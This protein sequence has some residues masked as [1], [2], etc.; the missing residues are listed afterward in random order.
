MEFLFPKYKKIKALAF[1]PPCPMPMTSNNIEMEHGQFGK[2]T[3][4]EGGEEEEN[5]FGPRCST[6]RL[7]KIHSLQ[8]KQD[9]EC[10]EGFGYFLSP[11]PYSL[12]ALGQLRNC[13][14]QTKLSS[15]HKLIPI[16]RGM[17]L[18][19][20]KSNHPLHSRSCVRILL[21]SICLV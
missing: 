17:Q 9:N 10:L 8:K 21:P 2:S 6:T 13:F 18:K 11:F 16:A 7:Y 19:Q 14:A 1:L 15:S 3:G 12:S 20:L 5:P 4:N